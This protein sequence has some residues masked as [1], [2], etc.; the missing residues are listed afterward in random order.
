MKKCKAFCCEELYKPV[1]D[2][3]INRLRNILAALVNLK[4][5]IGEPTNDWQALLLTVSR[6]DI[7]AIRETIKNLRQKSRGKKC[8]K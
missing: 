7:P 1:K 8:T 3:E 2:M 4:T 5:Q 6:W